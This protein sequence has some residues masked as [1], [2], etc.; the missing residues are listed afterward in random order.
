MWVE[1]YSKKLKRMIAGVEGTSINDCFEYLRKQV[2]CEK[3]EFI[4]C[5]VF[6]NGKYEGTLRKE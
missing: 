1:I 5:D 3:D 4:G 2:H 6:V